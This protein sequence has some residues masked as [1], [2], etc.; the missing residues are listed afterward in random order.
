MS[1]N[2]YLSFDG[3]CREAFELYR[4]VFGGEFSVF[5][6]FG[7]GPPDMGVSEADKDRVMHVSLPIGS[8]VLMGSDTCSAFGPPPVIGSNFEIALIGESREHCD[9]LFARLSEG[10]S[11]RMP[12]QETFWGACFGK[13]TD[14]FGVGW[15]VN[16]ELPADS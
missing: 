9:T 16:Y 7:E 10:G 13:W 11:T 5:M 14:K 3:T 15:M 2:V 4:S 12:M 1:Y 8:G 6:T